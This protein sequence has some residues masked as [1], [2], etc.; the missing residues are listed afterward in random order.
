MTNTPTI[1]QVISKI[2]RYFQNRKF[3][4]E[5]FKAVRDLLE[6][7]GFAR[8]ASGATSVAYGHSKADFIVK[9]A[10]D[11][12]LGCEDDVWDLLVNNEIPIATP[13][14]WG[15]NYFLKKKLSAYQRR[16]WGTSEREQ[17][18]EY[19]IA[20]SP[21]VKHDANNV[22]DF[23][24]VI[25]E[26]AIGAGVHTNGYS[27]FRHMLRR[28]CDE[29]GLEMWDLHHGNW[30]VDIRGKFEIFDYNCFSEVTES[31]SKWSWDKFLAKLPFELNKS[32]AA[33]YPKPA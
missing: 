22:L 26:R 7:M 12:N 6:T 2:K 24:K 8:L 29:V 25:A 33:L 15:M 31:P 21:R 9:M 5:T 20:I 32:Q 18:R 11:K 17:E 10:S 27:I 28:V 1:Q 16:M 4:K 13:I 14:L 30:T 23:C 3:D 19:C